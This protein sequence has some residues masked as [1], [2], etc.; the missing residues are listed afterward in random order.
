MIFESFEEKKTKLG[1]QVR[2]QTS[3]GSRIRALLDMSLLDSDFEFPSKNNE[4]NI[5]EF[6]MEEK[7]GMTRDAAEFQKKS[8]NQKRAPKDRT[9]VRYCFI[10]AGIVFAFYLL[11]KFVAYIIPFALKND[12]SKIKKF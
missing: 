5:F 9:N 4:Q 11:P 10:I 12:Y 3:T 7:A 2:R 8:P 1:E 6:S